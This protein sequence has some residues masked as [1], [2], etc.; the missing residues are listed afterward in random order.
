MKSLDI[1]EDVECVTLD[2][3]DTLWPIEPTISNAE[4]KLYDWIALKYPKV[5][6]TYSFEQIAVKKSQLSL[7]RKDIAH[8]VTELRHCA[9]LELAEEF[10]YSNKFADDG[11]KV[12]RKFRNQVKPYPYSER[13]L[14]SPVSIWRSSS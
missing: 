12:F 11:L 14:S 10:G 7:T 9:L 13:L 3:D 4:Q 8:N 5:T 2:L 1:I 6:E